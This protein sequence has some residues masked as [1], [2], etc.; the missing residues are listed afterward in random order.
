M[1]RTAI[2]LWCICINPY[3]CF[4]VKFPRQSP[5]YLTF[6]FIYN[7]Y[8]KA[9]QNEN[10]NSWSKQDRKSPLS[11]VMPQAHCI[12]ECRESLNRSA[13]TWKKLTINAITC[14]FV[15]IVRETL[16]LETYFSTI[17]SIIVLTKHRMLKG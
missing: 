1:L 10:L 15:S 17:C 4:L 14:S 2:L 3:L 16:F 9:G 7:I 11:L 8:I 12:K 6:S 5:F 13:I